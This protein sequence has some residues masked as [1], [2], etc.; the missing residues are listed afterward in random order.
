M[1]TNVVAIE[2]YA[3][4]SGRSVAQLIEDAPMDAFY[5]HDYLGCYVIERGGIMQCVEL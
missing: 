5:W 4:E 3:T 1:D 2:Q